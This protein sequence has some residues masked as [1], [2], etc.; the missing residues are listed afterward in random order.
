MTHIV[1]CS[2]LNS[3]NIHEHYKIHVLKIN[4]PYSVVTCARL[5]MCGIGISGSGFTRPG[6]SMQIW[7]GPAPAGFEKLEFVTSLYLWLF[8]CLRGLLMWYYN[9]MYYGMEIMVQVT[10]LMLT[11]ACFPNSDFR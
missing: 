6:L 2:L 7:P 10:Q 8:C 5:L 1:R 4:T 11:V 9:I 3:S